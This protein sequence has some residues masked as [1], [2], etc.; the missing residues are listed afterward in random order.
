MQT[1]KRF[2]EYTYEVVVDK[3]HVPEEVPAVLE[4][5]PIVLPA[6]DLVGALAK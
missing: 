3:K 4:Q 2:S 5:E 6:W 1:D